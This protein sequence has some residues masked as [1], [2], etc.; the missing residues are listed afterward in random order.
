MKIHRIEPQ[1]ELDFNRFFN[2][3]G[4]RI[5]P[6]RLSD[7][8]VWTFPYVATE[9]IRRLTTLQD[10]SAVAANKTA[11]VVTLVPAN[12]Y[13]YIHTAYVTHNDV[14][15]AHTLSFAIVPPAPGITVPLARSFSIAQG[16]VLGLN[17]LPGMGGGDVHPF[18]VPPGFALIGIS[19]T[20][21]GAGATLSLFLLY[22][23]MD[24]A[25]PPPVV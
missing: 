17:S 16:A 11:G 18:I 8:I 1:K 21:M 13:W 25:E 4:E 12:K 23:Q 14:G 10:Q 2:P 9:F 6:A 15:A 20:N 7:D 24:I 19:D 22:A 5:Q 3:V